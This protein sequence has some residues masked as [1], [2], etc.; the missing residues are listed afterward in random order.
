MAQTD[1]K[2]FSSNST[3]GEV[4]PQ[5]IQAVREGAVENMFSCFMAEDT[6]KRLRVTM[7]QV[8][9]AIDHLGLRI[10]RCQLG[11]FGYPPESGILV[12]PK[13]KSIKVNG[14]SILGSNPK[15]MQP[16][17]EVIRSLLVDGCLSCRAAWD[18]ALQFNIT[19]RDVAVFCVDMK[20][21]IKTCQLGV[22]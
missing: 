12:K 2:F 15:I 20:I 4:D 1:T 13:D 3:G 17:E 22:F 16:V 14:K 7:E 21:K 19:R 6:M 5:I 11:L 10:Y 18:V 9:Q 8:R